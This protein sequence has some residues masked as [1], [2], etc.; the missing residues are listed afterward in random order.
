MQT[1]MKTREEFKNTQGTIDFINIIH[2]LIVAMNSSSPNGSL[3][4]NSKE[5]EVSYN[6]YGLEHGYFQTATTNIINFSLLLMK[7]VISNF[8]CYLRKWYELGMNATLPSSSQKRNQK[9]QQFL[10]QNTFEGLKATLTATLQLFTF[11]HEIYG[12]RYLM[13]SRLNQNNLEVLY[14]PITEFNNNVYM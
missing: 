5:E 10:T 4:K 8:L 6:I 9:H 14:F 11:L 2:E 3:W 7:Q 13:T 12:Y 1:L